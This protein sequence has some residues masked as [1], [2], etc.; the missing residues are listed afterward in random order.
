M[1]SKQDFR[2]LVGARDRFGEHLGRE[3][4]RHVQQHDGEHSGIADHAHRQ[5]ELVQLSFRFSAW[6]APPLQQVRKDEDYLREE[7]D[8]DDADQDGYDE[9]QSSLVYRRER[10]VLGDALDDETVQAHRRG[11]GSQ[12]HHQDDVDA[13]PDEVDPV[14]L[15]RWAGRWARSA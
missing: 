9:R 8:E 6:M 11:D 14:A 15:R 5:G 3:D 12:F 1:H 13:E 7:V 4:V 10:D 2:D